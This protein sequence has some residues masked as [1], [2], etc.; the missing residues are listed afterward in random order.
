MT[1]AVDQRLTDVKQEGLPS[2]QHA[3]TCKHLHNLSVSAMGKTTKCRKVAKITTLW[4]PGA[5]LAFNG[6][7]TT[8]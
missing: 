7:G 3:A 6:G 5:L 4:K 8:F 2:W 1:E